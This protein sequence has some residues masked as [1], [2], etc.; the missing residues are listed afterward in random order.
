MGED[1]R[2]D[3]GTTAGA[4][5]HTTEL[6]AVNE[7][8]LLAGL[9]EQELAD[10]L[11]RQLAFTGAI[12]GNLGEGVCALDDACRVTFANHAAER[13]LGWAEAELLGREWDDVVHGGRAEDCPP[14]DAVR[15]GVTC[16]VDDE[17]FVRRD[18][19]TVAVAYTAAPIVADGEVVGTVVVF[20]DITE[21]QHAEAERAAL[22][23]RVQA[24]LAFRTRFISITAHELKAPLAVLKGT[25]QLLLRQAHR[26]GSERPLRSLGMIDGQVDRM[27]RLI[28]DLSDVARIESD[29]LAFDAQP[30]DVRALLTDTIT[31]VSLAAPDFA[32][33]LQVEGMPTGA[34]WVRGDRARLG[35]VL[36]NL[37]TNAVKYSDRHREAEIVLRRDGDRAAIAVT[38]HGI[39]IPAAQQ[40]D[41]FE[42][43]ARADNA[44]AGGYGG[45]GLGL[46]ISKAIVDRHGGTLALVSEEG[47]GSTFTLALPLLPG[48]E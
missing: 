32:L 18:G 12:V 13:L 21:R 31:E 3:S 19:G 6:R 4:P 30:L 47:V 38:D 33:H 11:R 36:T 34:V 26:E 48:A 17:R 29:G 10:Q 37:L 14:L 27:T 42:P 41:I 39:G 20:R 5:Q 44:A 1:R 43:Y 16:R 46:F 22:L 2:A 7:R 9:R 45:L 35:Q 25:A 28:D 15:G 40:A 23:A 8:L 24:A